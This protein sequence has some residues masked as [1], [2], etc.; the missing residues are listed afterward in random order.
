MKK[1]I[2][3]FL[4]LFFITENIFA[5]MPFSKHDIIV[6]EFQKAYKDK[7]LTN[8][9][10]KTNKEQVGYYID[11]LKLSEPFYDKNNSYNKPHNLKSIKSFYS[12][13]LNGNWIENLSEY[14]KGDNVIIVAYDPS[15]EKEYS[16]EA[17]GKLVC[18]NGK[19]DI[20]N[21]QGYETSWDKE[22]W[23]CGNFHPKD[24]MTKKELLQKLEEKYNF[25]E[26][27][28]TKNNSNKE[29]KSNNNNKILASVIGVIVGIFIV[30]FLN[31]RKNS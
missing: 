20:Q 4:S 1:I 27:E 19:I 21:A 17:I 22:M 6:G 14:K 23:W 31:K 9:N 5:C 25:C 29:K 13:G 16:V 28:D 3:L 26:T 18:K 7:K 10:Y 11:I 8:I 12:D 15:G 30:M 2:I 24:V